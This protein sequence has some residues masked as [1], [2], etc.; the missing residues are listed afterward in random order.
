MSLTKKIYHQ[1]GEHMMAQGVLRFKYQEEKKEGGMTALAGLP[2]YLD[3]AH[4][5]GLRDSITRHVRVREGEQGWTDAQVVLSLVLLNLAG[6]DCVDDLRIL[7]GDEGFCRV[8]ERV[9]VHGMNRKERRELQRRWRKE[10]RRAVPSPSSVFRYLS[11]FHDEEQERNREPHRAFIPKRNGHLEGLGMVNRDLVSFVQGR[12]PQRV[13]TFDIDATVV[14]TNKEE[15]LYSYRGFKAYQPLNVYWAEQD[16]LVHSEFR[17]GNVP[18]GYEKLR[19]FKEVLEHLPEGIERVYLRTDTAG[20]QQDLLKHCAEGKDERFGVIEFVIGVDVTEEFKK[21]VAEVEDGEWHP[22]R[23]KVKDKWV[24][25]G[26]EW[27]EV[28]FV[29]NWV[30]HSKKGP[31]YRYLAT[32]EPLVGQLA[33]SGMEDQLPF[34]TMEFAEGGRYKVFG[35]V[36]NRQIPGDE[37]IRWHRGRCGKS[38]EAHSVMKEDLAG[39]KFPSRDFGENAAWWAMMILA[40]NLNSA[41]KQLV[42]GEGWVSKRLKAIRFA[43]INLPGRIMERSRQLMVRLACGHP[44]NEILFDARKRILCLANAPPG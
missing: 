11:W 16:L 23:R 7:E 22:L 44:S 37:L 28:C 20:Y 38:E 18:A 26:Q 1:R 33:F 4:V 39:G 31:D 14:E 15:A 13:A 41:M 43:L 29:P 5:V 30:G 3:L 9:E 12:S 17:D 25:T 2:T 21:A 40:F 10:R 42:L 34:P 35:L 19:V 27:A 6:G 24:D 32:R 36:T 8:L